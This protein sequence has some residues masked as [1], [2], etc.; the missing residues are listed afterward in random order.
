MILLT[1]HTVVGGYLLQHHS[2]QCSLST[3]I[4]TI[5]ECSRAKIALDP[6]ADAVKFESIENAP[7]GC[8]RFE[9][10]WFFNNHP[11][12]KADSASEPVCKSTAG[13]E[14]HDCAQGLRNSIHFV[15]DCFCVEYHITP[16]M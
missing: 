16:P 7:S 5:D 12:G 6:N 15:P 14:G 1:V 3:M 10:A 9:G 11:T 4:A 8:S 13:E 2:K